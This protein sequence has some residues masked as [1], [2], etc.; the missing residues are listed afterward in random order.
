M[1]RWY[2]YCRVAA[3]A[4]FI[5]LCR[6]RVFG[7][8]NV[9][10]TGGVLLVCNHQSFFDPIL[11]TLALPRECHYMARDSLFRNRW[12][13]RL[14]ESLN[15]FPI[16]RATADVGAIK[17]TLRRLKRGA[18]VTAFPEATR[19]RDGSVRPMQP[20]V[21]LLARKARVPLV[22]A[23]ILGAYEAWPRQAAL[24]RPAPIIVA[25]APPLWPAQME[26]RSDEECIELV[27]ARILEMMMRY[28]RH[29]VVAGRLQPLPGR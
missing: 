13:R 4:L 28:R 9:P 2:R 8:R 5:V 27:R 18:L 26:G 7:R 29:P 3:N 14:I 15:A 6:G 24:P 12:F 19:T 23:L 22:P 10:L 21:V 20:G 17:E 1:R 25:Y 11:A 16:K